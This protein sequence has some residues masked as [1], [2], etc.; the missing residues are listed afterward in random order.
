MKISHVEMK[1][2][3]LKSSLKM[4]DNSKE[5]KI[6]ILKAQTALTF[7]QH[8]LEWYLGAIRYFFFFPQKQ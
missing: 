6:K 8:V 4:K 3:A 2:S 7:F 5:K 1:I